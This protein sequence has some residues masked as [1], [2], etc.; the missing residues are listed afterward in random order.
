VCAIAPATVCIITP[1]IHPKLLLL[2][3]VSDF[4][5]AQSHRLIKRRCEKR[6]CGTEKS[7]SIN[8]SDKA[9]F[10][11]RTIWTG[12]IVLKNLYPCKTLMAF[13]PMIS[14]RKN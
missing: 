1:T 12:H 5:E 13:A 9:A 2:S 6:A 10:L 11:S 14:I 4:H 7:C 8:L 3:K